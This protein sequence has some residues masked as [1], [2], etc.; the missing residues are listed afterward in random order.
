MAG[1]KH[2][3]L[4]ESFYRDFKRLDAKMQ[5]EVRGRLR[6]LEKDP[7][8]PNIRPHRINQGQLPKLFS[9]DVYSNKSHK[10]SYSIEGD[11]ITVRRVATHR[12]I[13]RRP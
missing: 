6:D 3:A 12:E 2:V 1:I 11:T 9:I 10:I 5:E 7:M 8:P 4:A 13:D